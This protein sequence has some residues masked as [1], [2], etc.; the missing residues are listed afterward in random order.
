MPGYDGTGPLGAGSRT[1]LGS[2]YCT[3]GAGAGAAT[4]RIGVLR[5]VGRGGIPRGG[6]HG[7][8]FGGRGWWGWLASGFYPARTSSSDYEVERLREELAKAHKA[9]QELEARLAELEKSG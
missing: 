1:G 2:G 9:V 8:C 4:G 3:Q 5:G 6:G 7:R